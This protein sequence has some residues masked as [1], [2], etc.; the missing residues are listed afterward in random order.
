MNSSF[1]SL[2]AEEEDASEFGYSSSQFLSSW[3][4]DTQELL[5]YKTEIDD[6]E[7]KRDFEHLKLRG[8]QNSIGLMIRKLLVNHQRQLQT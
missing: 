1:I 2:G 3:S 6:L 5:D 8:R 4:F 7:E